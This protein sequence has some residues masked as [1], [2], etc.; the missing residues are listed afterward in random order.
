MHLTQ[1]ELER[2][3]HAERWGPES[4]CVTD[5]EIA[6][7][8]TSSIAALSCINVGVIQ[9]SSEEDEIHLVG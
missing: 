9:G 4:F 6:F 7:I 5:A 2:T 8:M 3:A 1:R